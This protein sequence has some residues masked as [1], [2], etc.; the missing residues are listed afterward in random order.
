[1][2]QE[3]GIHLAKGLFLISSVVFPC[4]HEF[5]S[6]AFCNIAAIGEQDGLQGLSL[7]RKAGDAS[8][9]GS[10]SL[11]LGK[12]VSRKGSLWVAKLFDDDD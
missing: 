4:E 7:D 6:N 3:D 9:P 12:Q 2:D 5:Y 8:L 10:L 11:F 1:M